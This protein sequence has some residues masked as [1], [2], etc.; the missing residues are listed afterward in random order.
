MNSNDNPEIEKKIHLQKNSN[1]I[2]QTDMKKHH[3]KFN[4]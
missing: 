3:K 4:F 1:F 2:S